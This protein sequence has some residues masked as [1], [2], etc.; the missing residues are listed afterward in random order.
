MA[1]TVGEAPTQLATSAADLPRR[2]RTWRTFRRNRIALVGLT[3]L[4][5]LLLVA[6]FGPLLSPYE[7]NDVSLREKHDPPSLIHPLGTD[8]F[9]RD[10]LT[11]LMYG[12]RISLG[13]AIL[14]ELAG[15]ILGL[16]VGLLGSYFGRRVDMLLMRITDAFLAFPALLFALAIM[17]VRGPG[18]VSLLIA[19]T[20]RGWTSY[21][22]LARAEGLKIRN[23]EYIESAHVLGVPHLHVIG[24]H[25]FPNMVSTIIVFTTLSLP[26]PI[27]AEAA[28]SFL[29]LGL[30][31][32]TPSLGNMIAV[33]RGYM[34]NA[35]WAV[36]FPGLA[37]AITVLA[38][39]FLG[40]GVRDA[41][42]P[43]LQT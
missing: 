10:V 41:L 23:L 13:I 14:V 34:R 15:L 24:R 25:I 5:V 36:T 40:D 7:P 43:R 28:L 30:P 33:D 31:I 1:A 22:R 19:L 16:T 3:M 11:R 4:V 17:A 18:F 2:R 29:G 37:V 26:I 35:W 42:D 32:D 20:I 9:G 8:F 21:A 6:I 27:L 39:N 12:L 38:F